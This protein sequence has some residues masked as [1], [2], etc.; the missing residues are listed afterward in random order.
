MDYLVLGSG[1]PRRRELLQKAGL[2]FQICLPQ[3]C[4]EPWDGVTSPQEYSRGLALT[5]GRWVSLAHP[6]GLVLSADTIVALPG[7]ILG[8]PRD[9]DH[10]RAMLR[11]LS[12][13]SHFVHTGVA[14]FAQGQELQSWCA[15]TRVEFKA[16]DDNQI[17]QY[18]LGSAPLDK[19]GG[20]AYQSPEGRALVRQ[21]EGLESTVIGLPVEEVLPWVQRYCPSAFS[22]KN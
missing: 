14:L 12:G 10:A 15:T 4:E 11:A 9:M 2:S 20:Y 1:S 22:A 8:K 13:R 7:E 16:L 6:Q 18:L 3:C 21:I 5:K 17:D 19:A